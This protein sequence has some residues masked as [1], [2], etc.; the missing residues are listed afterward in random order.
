M[1]IIDDAE[2]SLTVLIKV[3][4]VDEVSIFEPL[5]EETLFTSSLVGE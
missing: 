1:Y 5:V 3:T 2:I 4:I